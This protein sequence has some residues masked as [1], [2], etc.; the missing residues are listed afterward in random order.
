MTRH[1]TDA[2][3]ST[4]SLVD[5]RASLA[6]ARRLTAA[7]SAYSCP[8]GETISTDIADNVAQAHLRE[9]S[10]KAVPGGTPTTKTT[11]TTSTSS[12][13]EPPGDF[14]MTLLP[15]HVAHRLVVSA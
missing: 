2:L 7:L 14:R 5:S 3:L 4:D 6:S 11:T 12:H 13:P 10:T 15:T 1:T 8:V 9:R